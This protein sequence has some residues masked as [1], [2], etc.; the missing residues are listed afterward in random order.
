[1]HA[2]FRMDAYGWLILLRVLPGLISIG[3]S[4]RNNLAAA[5]ASLVIAVW[6]DVVLGW[7]ARKRG[8]KK[9]ATHV[10]LDG[11]VDFTCFIWAPVQFVLIQTGNWFVPLTALVFIVSGIFRLARF[12]VEGVIDGGYRGLPV[13][14]NGYFFPLAAFG[15][16][17]IPSLNNEIVYSLLFAL[18]AALMSSKRFVT[19]EL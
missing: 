10:Q 11:F 5:A 14:Y 7:G 17:Y 2:A 9:G 8:W 4:F 3:F 19:P 18:I 6:F 12:N 13:T 16:Y 1:M 15:L